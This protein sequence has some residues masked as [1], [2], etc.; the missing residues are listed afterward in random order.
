MQKVR[1]EIDPYNRLIVDGP[2]AKSDLPK[3]RK[4]LDGKFRTDKNN[5]LSYH[6]KAPLSEGSAMPNQVKLSG[7]WS[8]TDN[9]ELSLK[10]DKSCRETFGDRI[11]LQ[12]DILDVKQNSLLFA[13]TTAAKENTR[14]TYVLNIGGRWKAD[15]N[16][17]LSFHVKREGGRYDILTFK[18]AWEVNKH[19]QIIYEYEKARLIRKKRQSHTLTFKG[20]WDI[21]ERARISYVLSADTDSVFDFSTGAGIFK[22]KYI[23]YEVGI[24]LT[25]RAKKAKRTIRLSGKWNL[26]KGAGLIF[27]V[28]YENKRVKAIVFGAEAKLTDKDTVSFR[29]KNDI[30]NKD[31]GVSMELSH[32]IFRGDG[33]AFLRALASRRESAVYAGTAWR[34]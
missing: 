27:E 19:H 3:F 20:Y 10:L 2:G 25:D 11:T 18:G 23:Q 24:G 32:K 29:L 13:V 4:V 7:Q 34:W 31:I 28:E 16:N 9:H 14:S 8:L 21:K 30:E 5:N 1:Y 17:R 22:E 15:E 6:I 33:E 12:G 26:K